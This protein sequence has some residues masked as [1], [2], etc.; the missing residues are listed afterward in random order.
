MYIHLLDHEV[1]LTWMRYALALKETVSFVGF[2]CTYKTHYVKWL[3]I[4]H[5]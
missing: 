5:D 2:K 4:Y 3:H 1:K